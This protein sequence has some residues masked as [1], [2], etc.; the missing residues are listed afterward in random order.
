M[1][2]YSFYSVAISIA[3]LFASFFNYLWFHKA[4]HR[5]DTDLHRMEA[6]PEE[7]A[8]RETGKL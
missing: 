7:I 4:E 6:T 2:A 1:P 8:D 3:N 5:E